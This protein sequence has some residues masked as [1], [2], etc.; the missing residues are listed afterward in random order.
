MGVLPEDAHG[1]AEQRAYAAMVDEVIAEIER[2]Q[3]GELARIHGDLVSRDPDRAIAAKRRLDE[4]ITAAVGS[5]ALASRIDTSVR[6]RDLVQEGQ[7]LVDAG[8]ELVDG[9]VQLICAPPRGPD[10]QLIRLGQV[11]GRFGDDR[12]GF[13][14][15]VADIPDLVDTTDLLLWRTLERIDNGELTPEPETRLGAYAATRGY[16]P[17]T[18]GASVHRAIGTIYLT[19]GNYGQENIGR[20]FNSPE[21]RAL[22]DQPVTSCAGQQMAE[23]EYQYWRDVAAEDSWS[24]GGELGS[25]FNPTVRDFLQR[26]VFSN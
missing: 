18:V 21:A 3:P 13:T 25:M 26:H 19:F 4:T 10:D 24:P 7:P 14:G 20:V 6:P 8:Q 22:Y 16:A 15:R 2:R 11:N 17:G 9:G 5:P 12:T 1:T 23:L